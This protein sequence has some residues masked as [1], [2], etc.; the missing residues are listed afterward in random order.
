MKIPD[1]YKQ[2]QSQPAKEGQEEK[3]PEKSSVP[4]QSDA[5]KPEQ[6]PEHKQQPQV[7]QQ[8]PQIKDKTVP[9]QANDFKLDL[10]EDWEDKTIYTLTGPVT[11]GIQ[12]NVIIN[13]DRNIEADSLQEFAEWQI[14]S[15]E[16][17]LKGC[18]L[19]KRGET[20]LTNG[21]DAYEAI[22]KWYP[23]EDVCI[24]QHQIYVLIEKVAYKMTAS[25]T[26]KTRQTIG[27]AVVRM[28]LS[29]NPT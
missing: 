3:L 6:K 9:Y 5:K 18:T 11:D 25:F 15:L 17:E 12:H 22:F 27:P 23:V 10:L 19:L 21:T 20:K 8:Q 4:K 7:S 24:Y 26:K 2:F 14:K 1:Y 29:F 28:M 16:E 13:V